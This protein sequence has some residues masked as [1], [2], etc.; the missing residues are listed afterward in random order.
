MATQT[1]FEDIL[2]N[3]SFDSIEPPKPI[4]AGQYTCIVKE[5]RRDRSTK[6]GT[7]YVEYTLGIQGVY[8]DS[9]DEDELEDWTEKADGT[10]R[11][12][13]DA[14]LRVTFY[15][16]PNSEYRWAAFVRHCGVDVPKGASKNQVFPLPV[17]QEVIAT[18]KHTSETDPS[19]EVRI[20]ANVTGTAPV[21]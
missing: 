13:Q 11:N 20:F 17:N 1:S 5:F 12:L 6:K 2:G 3:E 21:K 9:V 16:T 8:K 4:P 18:V 7:E 19:G 15:L 10:E 14:T